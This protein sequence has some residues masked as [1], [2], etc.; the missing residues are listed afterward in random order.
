MRLLLGNDATV[1]REG[2]FDQRGVEESF[3]DFREDDVFLDAKIHHS[4]A[5]SQFF[6]LSKEFDRN[7]DRF[8]IWDGFGK[9]TLDQGKSAAVGSDHV[10]A[11][12]TSFQ[13]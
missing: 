4:I 2:T 10:H 8:E 5:G 3:R 13:K 12:R 11:D 6:Q 1:I 7:D 9:L